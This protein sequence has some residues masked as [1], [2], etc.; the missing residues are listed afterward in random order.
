MAAAP[1]SLDVLNQVAGQPSAPAA[2]GESS[3]DVLN[4]VS[5]DPHYG[6]PDVAGEA[7]EGPTAEEQSFLKSNPDHKYL[8]SDP[9]FPNRPPGIYPTGKGNE[10]RQDPSYSQSPVDLDFAKHTA[11]GAGMAAAGTLGGVAATS[12]AAATIV[13]G[14]GCGT[15]YQLAGYPML[16]RNQGSHDVG[17][18]QPQSDPLQRLYMALEETGVLDK[19]RALR[20]PLLMLLGGPSSAEGG[21][22]E[23]AEAAE[24]AASGSRT[25]LQKQRRQPQHQHQPRQRQPQPQRKVPKSL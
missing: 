19:Y 21:A 14:Q 17:E 25:C 12:P 23:G 10:W 13:C 2:G 7:T 9:K 6:T 20:I 4:K 16:K 15:H 24:G 1:S 18:E 22:A 11:E 5:A 8:P 3:L